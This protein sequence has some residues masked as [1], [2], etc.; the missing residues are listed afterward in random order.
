MS[1]E[2]ILYK[3]RAFLNDDISM[4]GF[5]IAV[6]EEFDVSTNRLGNTTVSSWS[7]I[8]MGDCSNK[9]SIDF[10]FHNYQNL[11]RA[12]KKLRLFREAVDGFA[13]AFEVE[14]KR[15]V[16]LKQ[17]ENKNKKEKGKKNARTK[18]KSDDT[19]KVSSK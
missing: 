11:A 18:R 7:S 4:S 19:T 8:D 1:K 16:E 17:A 5:I 9:I 10:G 12:L 3:K 6:L 14:A 15:V 13:D 2:K